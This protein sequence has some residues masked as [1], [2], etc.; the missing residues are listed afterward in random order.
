MGNFADSQGVIE[1]R[2]TLY[3]NAWRSGMELTR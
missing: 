1:Y 3:C 2:G